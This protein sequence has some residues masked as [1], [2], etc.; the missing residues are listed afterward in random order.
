MKKMFIMI[1]SSIV[2]IMGCAGGGKPVVNSVGMT[3]DQS[4]KEASIEID[5]RFEANS[6][7][8]LVNF[9]SS[10]EQFSVYVLDE[11]TANLVSSRHLEVI[12]RQ[13]IDLRRGEL[14]F[15]MSGEVSDESMQSLGRTLGAQNI[16][17]GSLT[18]IGNDYRIVIRALNVETGRV[19]VQYRQDIANDPRVQALLS[20]S[21]RT[22]IS[23]TTSGSSI[24][25]SSNVIA[26]NNVG[27]DTLQ[28]M[29][30]TIMMR[31]SPRAKI[32]ILW[33]NSNDYDLSNSIL[34]ELEMIF[35]NTNFTIVDRGLM[36]I[37]MSEQN[38]RYDDLARADIVRH[39][40]NLF[41]AEVVISGNIIG[42]GNSRQ[43]RIQALDVQ[44]GS[45][46]GGTSEQY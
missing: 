18:N 3:L 1:I 35:I 43:L 4:I 8:A 42:S 25:T 27:K 19:E 14:D 2:L 31:L 10:S 44:T 38:L 26:E 9:T 28:R 34:N 13:E 24:Q 17:S 32:L 33:I 5:G 21:G 41:G 45:I 16:V 7:I 30:N 37:I 29:A 46:L 12:D 11:L 6:K 22:A 20:S 40:G 39:M 23:S 36:E 15:Q